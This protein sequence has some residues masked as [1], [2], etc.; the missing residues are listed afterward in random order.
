MT[1]E[2]TYEIKYE[3]GKYAWLAVGKTPDEYNDVEE[4]V[5]VP[6]VIADE[7]K[8]LFYKGEPIGEFTRMNGLIKSYLTEEF[9]VEQ[10]EN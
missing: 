6:V 4:V 5:E 8:T 9:I 1:F 7:G 2:T 3:G 10:D